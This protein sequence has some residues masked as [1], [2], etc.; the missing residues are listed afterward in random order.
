MA[1]LQFLSGDQGLQHILHKQADGV[2]HSLRKGVVV[3]SLTRHNHAL[4]TIYLSN[5]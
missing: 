1:N 5:D 3:V 4:T 2:L